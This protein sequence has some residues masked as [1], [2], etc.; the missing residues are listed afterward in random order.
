MRD[1]AAVAVSFGVGSIV[2]GVVLGRF[3]LGK[4]PRFVDNPGASG[5][6]RQFGALFGVSIGLLDVAKGAVSVALA[7]GLGASPMGVA[8]SAVAA[9]AGHN[10][11]VWFAFRGGGGL[12]TAVGG[13]GSIAPVETALAIAVSLLTAL[14]FKYSPIYGKLPVSSLP[15]GAMAGLPLLVWMTW[16]TGNFAGLWASLLG[17]AAIGIRG[18]QML[19]EG[20][21]RVQGQ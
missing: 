19:A 8:L 17:T 20:Q 6:F 10:W 21:R 13:L 2:W 9:I 1:A 5:S 14:L 18:L 11:P 3:F 4:D 16:R 7:R 15:A 12:A